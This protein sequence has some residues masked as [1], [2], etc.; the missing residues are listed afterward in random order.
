M[1]GRPL[2]SK[3]E[4]TLQQKAAAWVGNEDFQEIARQGGLDFATA[5]LHDRLLRK[6]E[7]GDFFRTVCE[8]K[9]E[10]EIHA[11]VIGVVPGAFYETHRDTGADG[12]RVLSIARRLGCE[13]ELIPVRSFGR[14]EEN[15][16]TILQWIKSQAGRRIALISLSKGSAE[17]KYALSLPRAGEIFAQVAAWVS[18]SGMVQGTPLVDWLWARRLRWWAVRLMLW[19]GRHDAEALEQLRHGTGT[20]LEEWPEMPA[21]LRVVHVYGFP[22]ERHLQHRWAPRGYNRLATM[23]PNDGG[24]ILLEDL[25]GLPGIVCPIW[26]ADHYLAPSWDATPLLERVVAQALSLPLQ[27]SQ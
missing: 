2:I 24:G 22:L 12:A 9:A 13:A 15:A 10:P 4:A 27:A 14:L 16:A 6:A 8:A 11:D 20:L 7:C 18:F 26:G 17:V 23:G 21:H 25:L 3:T 5:V 19:W 1:T